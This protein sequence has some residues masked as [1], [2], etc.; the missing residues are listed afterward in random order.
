MMENKGIRFAGYQSRTS[1]MVAK[2]QAGANPAGGI[3]GQSR[4]VDLE[5]RVA[6]DATAWSLVVIA[7]S[8]MGQRFEVQSP[9]VIGRSQECDVVLY[10][11]GLS[12]RHC[13]LWIMNSCLWARDLG[14]TNGTYLN[15]LQ[16]TMGK[17]KAGDQIQLGDSV[18]R[19]LRLGSSEDKY[20]AAMNQ[21]A[22]SDDLT[23]LGNRRRFQSLLGDA[24]TRATRDLEPFAIVLLDLD[25]F[26]S[27]NDRYGHDVGDIVLKAC[28]A[29][30]QSITRVPYSVARIG[31]EEF[32]VILPGADRPTA[33]RYAERCRASI[34][35]MTFPQAGAFRVTASFGVAEWNQN[36]K[37]SQDLV[38]IADRRLYAAKRAGKN[39]VVDD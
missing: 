13:R 30:V 37:D 35:S 25:N 22:W 29:Q 20:H 33:T 6:P 38:K 31:G 19:V 27:I 8:S 24:I 23:G 34:A 26:K 39:C 3:T 10:G 11:D 28:A 21:H 14:S 9:L 17:L 36:A 4:C 1:L 5:D 16:V 32:V 18:V 15:G 7:G 12:R 2:P